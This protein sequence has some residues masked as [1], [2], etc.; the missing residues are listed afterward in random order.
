MDGFGDVRAGD[1]GRAGQVGDGAGNFQYSVIAAG[2]ELKFAHGVL[3]QLRALAVR[4]A[5]A[6]D[7]AGFERG[8]GFA[9]PLSLQ[10][11]GGGDARPDRR[12]S[13]SGVAGGQLGFGDGGNVDM[14]VDSVEQ[15]SGEFAPVAADLFGGAATARLAEI[16]A[17]TGVHGGDQLKAG[18]EL[19]PLS[20]A[21]DPDPPVFQ[22]FA[23]A[24]EDAAG[25]FGEFIEKQDAMMS[26]RNF[27]G[28]GWIA[29]VTSS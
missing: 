21:G 26:E 23:Q 17:G 20:G 25:E 3:E 8:I 6:V 11:V 24:L 7:V 14:Q 4:Q 13:F 29:A 1:M 18:R 15:R 9:L 27:A 10:G 2:G 28:A 19:D 16:A 12:R 22:G 5:M